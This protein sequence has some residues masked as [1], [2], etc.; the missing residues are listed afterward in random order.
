M[1]CAGGS[2]AGLGAGAIAGLRLPGSARFPVLRIFAAPRFDG[3]WSF[4][5][6]AWS[7]SRPPLRA[8]FFGIAPAFP[9]VAHR[10]LPSRPEETAATLSRSRRASHPSSNAIAVGHVAVLSSCFLV[11]TLPLPA[12]V[13]DSRRKWIPLPR[14]VTSYACSFHRRM[15]A[16]AVIPRA[17]N[18]RSI[19]KRENRVVAFNCR[20][21]RLR[22]A[23][24]SVNM[25]PVGRGAGLNGLQV[26][27]PASSGRN[28]DIRPARSSPT[29]GFPPT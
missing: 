21:N 19:R 7:C 5:L 15:Q 18:S 16:M 27:R 24:V 12:A 4:G 8:S 20:G 13:S 10:A 22:P 2:P 6:C 17:Q 23:L 25:P 28:N 3:P 14:T 29:R 26:G 11:T 1:V 9:R